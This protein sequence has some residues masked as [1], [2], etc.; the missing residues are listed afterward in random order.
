VDKEQYLPRLLEA[1]FIVI[2]NVRDGLVIK[3]QASEKCFQSEKVLGIS[4]ML[5][6]STA[7]ECES[8]QKLRLF[9]ALVE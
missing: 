7:Y 1:P 3:A 8:D 4:F 2:D 9:T 5:P 6:C